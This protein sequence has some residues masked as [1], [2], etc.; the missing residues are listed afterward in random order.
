MP[1]GVG[2]EL[3]NW[4]P[5]SGWSRKRLWSRFRSQ[6]GLTP[7]RA[8]QLIRFDHAVHLL[9]AGHSPAA[10]AESG[11]ELAARET[12][13]TETIEGSPVGPPHVAARYR[14][15]GPTCQTEKE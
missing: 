11:I 13:P 2:F 8:D 14:I 5:M 9:A 4:Q 3:R 7:K 15:V 1:A 10:A 6:V 12:L